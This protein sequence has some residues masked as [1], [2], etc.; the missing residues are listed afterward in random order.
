[1]C[2]HFLVCSQTW[3]Q[4]LV[5]SADILIVMFL[6]VSQASNCG[7]RRSAKMLAMFH[8]PFLLGRFVEDLDIEGQL[9]RWMAA[10]APRS[11]I[12]TKLA[13]IIDWRY[14]LMSLIPALSTELLSGLVPFIGGCERVPRDAAS[15]AGVLAACSRGRGFCATLRVDAR[16]LGGDE[17]GGQPG[18]R[19]ARQRRW[20]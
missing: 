12:A 2:V 5:G 8:Q 18:G 10:R 1:M 13:E 11:F 16:H 17:C 15:M 7:S 19:G 3:N 9:R 4:V 14:A 20:V 6:C